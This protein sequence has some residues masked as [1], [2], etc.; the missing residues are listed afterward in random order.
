MS[1]LRLHYLCRSENYQMQQK[2]NYIRFTLIR[3]EP[4]PVRLSYGQRRPKQKLKWTMDGFY[5]FVCPVAISIPAQ[6]G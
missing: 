4:R 6:L 1:P 2:K 3:S 5:A